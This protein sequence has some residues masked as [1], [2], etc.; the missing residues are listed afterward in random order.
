M[1][2]KVKDMK[3]GD[4]FRCAYG[5]PDNIMEA[6]FEKA[7]QTDGGFTRIH[8]HKTETMYDN[9]GLDKAELEVIG[10]DPHYKD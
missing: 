10:R 8:Y 1:I 3:P 4:I 5:H 7:D 6:V 9:D 2:V